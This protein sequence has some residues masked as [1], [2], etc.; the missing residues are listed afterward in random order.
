[1]KTPIASDGSE[2]SKPM[3]MKGNV[4]APLGG[5][6]KGLIAEKKK[7]TVKIIIA[8][9][10]TIMAADVNLTIKILNGKFFYKTF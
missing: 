2:G 8:M 10:K 9:K 3:I 7:L 5:N 1:M 6:V 4:Q